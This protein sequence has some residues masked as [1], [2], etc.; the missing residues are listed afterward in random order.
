MLNDGVGDEPLVALTKENKQG[1][2]QPRCSSFPTTG[3]MTQ[4]P[5]VPPP[6]DLD[7]LIGRR[8]GSVLCR[9]SAHPCSASLGIY[10][11]QIFIFPLALHGGGGEVGVVEGCRL[12]P[13]SVWRAWE[14]P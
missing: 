11:P 13:S 6:T 14:G 4:Q 10:P 12:S 8:L 2:N 5:V 3:H 1:F 7:Q 9:P